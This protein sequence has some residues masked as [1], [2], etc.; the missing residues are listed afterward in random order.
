MHIGLFSD[1][2]NIPPKEGINVHSYELLLKLS[3]MSG[4]KVTLFLCDRGWLSREVLEAQP[5]D[6][7]LVNEEQ[8]YDSSVISKIIKEYNVSITQTYMPYFGAKV[9]NKASLLAGVPS[10]AE[11]HD[12]ERFVVPVYFEDFE[13]EEALEFHENIQ[14]QWIDNASLVR[15]MSNHDYDYIRRWTELELSKLFSMPVGTKPE[16]NEESIQCS[17]SSAIFIG[18]ISYPPNAKGAGIIVDELAPVDLSLKYK[19][20]GRGSENFKANNVEGHGI[21]EDL[22]Q[23]LSTAAIGLS[24][25]ISGSGMKIKNLTYLK[26]GIPVL[27]TSLGAQGYPESESIIIEDDFSKWPEIIRNIIEDKTLRNLLSK[28]ALKVFNEYFNIDLTTEKLLDVYEA[29]IK[30]Y[31]PK[32]YI[33]RFEPSGIDM[34]HVYWLR[35]LREKGGQ[36]AIKPTLVKGNK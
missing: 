9:L 14:K 4:V 25:I 1:S 13:L 33:E 36:V 17:G 10:V 32:N 16:I 29:A 34:C 6:T 21:V 8:F 12:I 3:S 20:A 18:N 2:I 31:S 24:P 7:V 28:E 23:I 35:E 11:V 26:N 15:I 30:E 5:F 22:A 27:T 19:I